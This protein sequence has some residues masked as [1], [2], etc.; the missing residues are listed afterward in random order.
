MCSMRAKVRSAGP[1][2]VIAFRLEEAAKLNIASKREFL[3]AVTQ[4]ALILKLQ[5]QEE[6]AKWNEF[7]AAVP[8]SRTQF[9]NWSSDDIP[10]PFWVNAPSFSSNGNDTLK[11]SG[12]LKSVEDALINFKEALKPSRKQIR[13]ETIAALERQVK[14]SDGIRLIAE[15][16]LKRVKIEL[17][18]MFAVCDDLRIRLASAEREGQLASTRF[19][20]Q[21]EPVSKPGK[22]IS[23][24]R[25]RVDPTRKNRQ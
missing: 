8:T 16:E 7:I 25:K 19:A 13:G 22:V 18:E 4:K 17:A 12:L 6:I 15:D 24:N 5:T 11:K 10:R 23:L 1:K 2:P 20:S 21:T 3:V 9:N 14:L